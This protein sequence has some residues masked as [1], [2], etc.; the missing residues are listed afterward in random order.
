[1]KLLLDTHAFLWLIEGNEKLGPA[2]SDA[3]S[4]L[5]NVVYLSVASIWELSIK[6]SRAN[7]QLKL[8]EPLDEYVAKWTRVYGIVVLPI[9]K[10]HALQVAYLTDHHR[11][12]FD[13]LLVAQATVE[14]MSLATGD[15]KLSAYPVPIVW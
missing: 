14:K 2:A 4:D 10:T 5:S 11:D 3:I 15:G 12:P 6:T 1:V 9:E 8:A 13:R 7:P